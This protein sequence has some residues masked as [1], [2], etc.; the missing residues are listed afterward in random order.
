MAK[1]K[2]A[3]GQAAPTRSE[4]SDG[5]G[6]AILA[7]LLIGIIWYFADDKM[8][9]NNFVKFHV[10]Q[11]LVLMIVSIIV[12]VALS[13]LGLILMWIPIIG[14]VILWILWFV[15]GVGSFVLWLMGIIAAATSK[16]KVLPVIGEFAE[17]LKF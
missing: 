13:I 11:A 1:E 3:K 4:A 8:R 10:K 9:K 12:S 15:F 5:M 7:Y 16:Q 6:C 14:W 2:I 17:K